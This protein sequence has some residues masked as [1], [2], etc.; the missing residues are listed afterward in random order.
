[1]R[2][3]DLTGA[4]HDR[5]GDTRL[6]Q[7]GSG[8]LGGL[9]I[10]GDDH[11]RQDAEHA[12]RGGDDVARRDDAGDLRERLRARCGLSDR[13]VDDT[14]LAASHDTRDGECVVAGVDQHTFR[15]GTE[16][17]RDRR[18]VP[19]C[20]LDGIAQQTA[21][22]RAPEGD[23]LGRRVADVQ[24]PTQGGGLR[25][26]RLALAL[27]GME[28]LAQST[29]GGFGI[30]RLTLGALIGRRVLGGRALGDQ[31]GI[32][33]GEL[34]LRLRTAR[35]GRIERPLLPFDGRTHRGEC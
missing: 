2:G 8:R 3:V 24:S 32:D 5:D 20:H 22:T 14:E 26:Q 6:G 25:H 19:G 11:V 17:R 1:M 28:A 27:R 12:L 30:R 7:H 29:D 18:L 13:D 33:P 4:R 21:D 23:E 15:E 16:S 10:L 34:G 35:E 31:L 9:E